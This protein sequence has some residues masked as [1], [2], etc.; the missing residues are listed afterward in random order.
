[1]KSDSCFCV[2][3]GEYQ[4]QM[5]PYYISWAE[6][7]QLESFRLIE[8][9]AGV[10]IQS[11]T[12]AKCYCRGSYGCLNRFNGIAFIQFTLPYWFGFKCVQTHSCWMKQ[13]ILYSVFTDLLFMQ[14]SHWSQGLTKGALLPWT[15]FSDEAVL[16]TKPTVHSFICRTLKMPEIHIETWMCLLLV[17]KYFQLVHIWSLLTI[18]PATFLQWQHEP[19]IRPF[20][21][22]LPLL[23]M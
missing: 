12:F 11:L 18:F 17:T 14:N 21:P 20:F 5:T 2:G 23:L 15:H 10:F 22:S 19:Y 4:W 13:Q 7:E 8:Q 6:V 9:P 1:M 16:P 3:C